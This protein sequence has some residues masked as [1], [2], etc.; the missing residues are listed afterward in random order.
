MNRKAVALNVSSDSQS[1]YKGTVIQVLLNLECLKQFTQ[2]L[3]DTKMRAYD[4]ASFFNQRDVDYV[5]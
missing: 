1:V 3:H 2:C 5:R 4:S